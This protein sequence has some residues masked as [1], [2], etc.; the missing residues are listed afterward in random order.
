MTKQFEVVNVKLNV[1]T[2]GAMVDLIYRDNDRDSDDTFKLSH[3]SVE[4]ILDARHTRH[5]QR[6]SNLTV[7]REYELEFD[8]I[9]VGFSV[10][11][12]VTSYKIHSDNSKGR[13]RSM[14]FTLD[15][16]I[17]N[18][19]S[20]VYNSMVVLTEEEKEVLRANA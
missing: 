16:A 14:K 3:E 17:L 10:T 20:D 11:L 6:W 18:I 19:L 7:N 8:A 5:R 12:T 15:S 2:K 9:P 13:V 1:P 4:H